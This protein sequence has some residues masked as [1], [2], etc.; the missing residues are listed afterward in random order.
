MLFGN[1]WNETGLFTE[2]GNRY[3][4]EINNDAALKADIKIS[5]KL[6][7]LAKIIKVDEIKF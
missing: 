5:S 2:K 3:R 1:I 6:L 7:N 4:F